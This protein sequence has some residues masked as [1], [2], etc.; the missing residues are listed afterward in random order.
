[1]VDGIGG[2]VKRLA[3]EESLRSEFDHQIINAQGFYN[4]MKQKNLKTIPFILTKEE[5]DRTEKE[6]EL[7]YDNA[8]PVKGTQKYH[9]FEV[10][11]SDNN[12][13]FV[14]PFSESKQTIRVRINKKNKTY[15][16][17]V[18]LTNI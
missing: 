14:K 10:D 2:H 17:S 11:P 5:I 18:L 9:N 3:S 12:F 4:F 15:I 7:R 8:V 13:L 1:M 6:L 16:D